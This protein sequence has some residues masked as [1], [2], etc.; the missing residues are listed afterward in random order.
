MYPAVGMQPCVSLPPPMTGVVFWGGTTTVPLPG[1]VLFPG[2][3][4]FP[5]PEGPEEPEPCPMIVGQLLT[6]TLRVQPER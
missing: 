6:V 2:V 3:V 1:A 4:L 5:G